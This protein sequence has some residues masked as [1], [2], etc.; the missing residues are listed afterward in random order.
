[1]F[2][3]IWVIDETKFIIMTRYR[4]RGNLYDLPIFAVFHFIWTNK[5]FGS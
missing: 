2:Q 3:V 1:M 4:K 5:K